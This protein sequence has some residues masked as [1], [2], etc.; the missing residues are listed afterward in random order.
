MRIRVW[1]VAAF[2]FIGQAGVGAQ[3]ATDGIDAWTRGEFNRAVE[4]LQ[5]LAEP[6]QPDPAAAFFLGTMYETGSGVLRD[7]VRACALYQ[8]AEDGPHQLSII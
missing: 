1:V 2:L 6:G 3:T 8:R 7:L 5:P 4:I